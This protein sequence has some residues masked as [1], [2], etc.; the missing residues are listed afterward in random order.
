MIMALTFIT[1]LKDGRYL[2]AGHIQSI[3]QALR[4]R[5]VVQGCEPSVGTGLSVNIA[6][7]KVYY[8]DGVYDVS[9]TTVSL[10]SNS[11]GHV[12]ADLIVWDGSDQTVKVLEGSQYWSD[13]TNEYAIAP[14]PSDSH[15]LLALVIV[16]DGASSL[17]TNDLFDLRVSSEY[18]TNRLINLAF[19]D[20]QVSATG[21]AETEVK[22][23]R[24]AKTDKYMN[25]S[26][27]YVVA[28][29]WTSSGGYVRL[30]VYID[31]T[32]Y[33]ELGTSS[34]TEDV[35]YGSIDI[36][37]LSNGMHEVSIRLLND[38]SSATSYNQYL[39]VLGDV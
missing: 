6:S 33:L 39:N 34:T 9:S 25:I 2:W 29:L 17:S 26:K 3:A 4:G 11:S 18:S 21:T 27:I 30:R 24:F 22:T 14:L 16:P 28:S 37:S 19:D 8:E 31:G 32:N 12:R 36:S 15:V 5:Y 7:G 13:G 20:T 35:K 1:D 10:S 38:S 23:F